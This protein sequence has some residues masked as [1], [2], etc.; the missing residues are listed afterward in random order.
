MFC[1]PVQEQK[2]SAVKHHAQMQSGQI[3]AVS[4][5]VFLCMRSAHQIQKHCG[6]SS[7]TEH[8][9]MI[10]SNVLRGKRFWLIATQRTSS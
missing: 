5:V 4:L 7:S 6:V 3:I 10:N 1:Y 9:V 2:V 8:E